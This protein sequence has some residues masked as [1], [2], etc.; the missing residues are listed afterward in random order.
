MPLIGLKILGAGVRFV[1]HSVN[2]R[3]EAPGLAFDAYAAAACAPVQARHPPAALNGT[4]TTDAPAKSPAKTL[5]AWRVHDAPDA[6]VMAG[7]R[8]YLPSHLLRPKRIL[9]GMGTA[10]MKI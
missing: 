8:A 6:A 2:R 9:L 10:L 7:K 3:L 1:D 5:D 4:Q